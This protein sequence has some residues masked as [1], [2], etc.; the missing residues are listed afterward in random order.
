METTIKKFKGHSGS[1]IYL[2]SKQGK[3]FV[4]KIEN[5]D[6]NYERLVYLY[7]LGFPVPRIYNYIPGKL[8]DMEY[9]HGADMI[10]YLIRNNP[11]NILE[12]IE[13]MLLKLSKGSDEKDYSRIYY[14]N[15][16]WISSDNNLPFSVDQLI[17]RLPKILPQS[18]Y[19]GDLTLENVIHLKDNKYFLIDC[20]TVEYDSFIFDI[21]KLRQ[22]LQCKWFLR[23]T[24]CKLDSKLQY[25]QRYINNL[26][27]QA[28]DDSLLIL[29]LLRVYLHTTKG[30]VNNIFLLKEIYKLWK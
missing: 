10:T 14:K 21:A 5:I 12:F 6:R 19:H 15:L 7:K 24:N 23:N 16:E 20:V 2:M 9:I 25:M 27:P 22:D 18:N 30:D 29:M 1:H 11:K 28:F 8:L 3:L 13:N 4:R 17:S 26:Y